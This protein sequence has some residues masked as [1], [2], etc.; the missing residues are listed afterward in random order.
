MSFE[1]K[2]SDALQKKDKFFLKKAHVVG[3]AVGRKRTGSRQFPGLAAIFFVDKKVRVSNLKPS[4]IL[5]ASIMVG[6]RKVRTDVVQISP[7]KPLGDPT[8]NENIG[9]A[10]P[11][12]MGFGIGICQKNVDKELFE[13]TLGAL[14]LD[15]T[16]TNM[17]LSAA[18]VMMYQGL[19]V[20]S[21]ASRFGG[22]NHDMKKF[23]PKVPNAPPPAMDNKGSVVTIA[24]PGIDAA[25]SEAPAASSQIVGINASPGAP[26]DPQVDL[27][28]KKS[29]LATGV[30]TGKIVYIG[31]KLC[32]DAASI[33][34]QEDIGT[35]WATGSVTRK[36]VT[37]YLR[38]N[39]KGQYPKH[40]HP[41]DG[42]N[43][44]FFV[45]SDTA[46]DFG[47]GGDSGALIVTGPPGN[48]V[49]KRNIAENSAV[50]LL[51]G[52]LKPTSVAGGLTFGYTYIVGQKIKTI[53][54][55][56]KLTMAP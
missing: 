21:P 25:Y 24:P 45:K 55:V 50:G 38:P 41:K 20:I 36:G 49:K 1:Q 26:V 17:L 13:G 43:D 16:N 52:I 11:L 42:M 12:L 22:H 15:S 31:G 27:P 5:P 28:V 35:L 8:A 7:L 3:Y 40:W 10:T 47:A 32:D 48:D 53:L 56:L 6:K 9:K 4:D 51:I 30:T 33:W 46:D 29:G 39:S 23:P 44:L 2:I 34:R 18:H 37:M 14:V 54:D 19:D